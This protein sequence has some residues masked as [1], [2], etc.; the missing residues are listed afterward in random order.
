MK[1]IL[2]PTDFSDASLNAIRYA[3]KIA[4]VSRASIMLFYVKSLF[5]ISPR[6]LLRGESEEVSHI[7]DSLEELAREIGR[8]FD[9]SCFSE[10]HVS[11]TVLSSVISRM[12]NEFDL[13]V[14]G[15]DGPD[16]LYEFF[17][18]SNTY[19]VIRNAAV[20][21]LMVPGKVGYSEIRKAVWAFDYFRKGFPPMEQVLDFQKSLKFDLTI[22][23][24]LEESY[25]ELQNSTLREMQ[26]VIREDLPE[27]VR[28]E[29]DTIHTGKLEDSVHQY[30]LRNEVDLMIVNTEHYSLL[31]RIFHRSLTK[32]IT[33]SG[34][35]PVLVLHQ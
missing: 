11:G 33:A 15:S 24:V 31:K 28:L 30:M 25:S 34:Q 14:M 22:L 7:Q 35:Y 6:D 29:F 10:V 1:K 18:G 17:L 16:N 20:P 4:Q 26:K 27:E 13:I 9:V 19:N 21:V 8:T 5:E 3:A 12:G 32:Q 23:Q 2:C